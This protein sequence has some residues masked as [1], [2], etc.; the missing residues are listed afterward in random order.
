MS[1]RWFSA[2]ARRLTHP[3]NLRLLWSTDR[4]TETF[5]WGWPVPLFAFPPPV[6]L[7]DW[8]TRYCGLMADDRRQPRR[9]SEAARPSPLNHDHLPYLNP[10]LP[11]CF[12]RVLESSPALVFPPSAPFYDINNP[13]TVCT[14]PGCK[15]ETF[16]YYVRNP[17]AKRYSGCWI[18]KCMSG[19][20]CYGWPKGFRPAGVCNYDGCLLVKVSSDCGRLMCA[21]HCRESGGCR[22][23]GHT[24]TA[25][26]SNPFSEPAAQPAQPNDLPEPKHPAVK[27]QEREE[28][29]MSALQASVYAEKAAAE[30]HLPFVESPSPSPPPPPSRFTLVE[31]VDSDEDADISTVRNVSVWVS[32]WTQR[33]EAYSETYH[34]WFIVPASYAHAIYT[35]KVVVVRKLGVVGVNEEEIF[36]FYFGLDPPENTNV[37][38]STTSSRTPSSISVAS[39]TSASA[40]TRETDIVEISDSEDEEI[41]V[42]SRP[43]A[44]STREQDV[45]DI[46]DSD[47]DEKFVVGPSAKRGPRFVEVD[48]SDD[49]DKPVPKRPK[50]SLTIPT[51]ISVTGASS[52]ASTP[53]LTMSSMSSSSLSSPWSG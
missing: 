26:P 5:T 24:P 46:A 4:L 21:P 13:P 48:S 11:G 18:L 44:V 51:S 36:D 47:E 38:Q 19:C 1:S 23:R 39:V 2:S 29:A 31:W 45:V 28:E 42:P 27:W 43:A 32:S 34:R 25:V 52:A 10:A 8:A 6:T 14:K 12:S 41:T 30:A 22:R 37:R 9:L 17:L 50:L 16:L 7:P 49:E 3:E 35:G 33:Y 15:G 53:A 40:A 20:F